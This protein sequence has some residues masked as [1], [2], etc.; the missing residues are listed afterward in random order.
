MIFNI[1]IEY[2]NLILKRVMLYSNILITLL[3]LSYLELAPV[4]IESL[5]E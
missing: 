3:S 1:E 5:I 4:T 2:N